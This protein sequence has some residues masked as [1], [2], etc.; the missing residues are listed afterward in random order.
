MNK[1][2]I[3]QYCT[4]LNDAWGIMIS[5]T[6]KISILSDVIIVDRSWNGEDMESGS[7]RSRTSHPDFASINDFIYYAADRRLPTILLIINNSLVYF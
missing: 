1:F 5:I 3:N 6:D 7:F 4:R 2:V